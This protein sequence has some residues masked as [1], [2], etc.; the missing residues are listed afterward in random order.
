M[1]IQQDKVI[2]IDSF[3]LASTLR[4]HGFALVG[5]KRLAPRK[6]T[7]LFEDSATLRN[8]I[9]QYYAGRVSLDPRQVFLAQDELKQLLYG[10]YLNKP[11]E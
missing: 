10:G 11:E 3:Q 6:A 9:K 8:V 1:Q 4:A 7:F 5:L 2:E